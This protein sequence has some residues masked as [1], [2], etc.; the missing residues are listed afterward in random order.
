MA[1]EKEIGRMPCQ[2]NRIYKTSVLFRF[3]ICWVIIIICAALSAD[4]M[5]LPDVGAIDWNHQAAPP[6][7]R[8]TI[9]VKAFNGK[10]VVKDYV[11]LCGTDPLGRDILTRLIFGARVSLMV[12]FGAPAGALIIGGVIGL[13]AG[14]YRGSFETVTSAGMD[15]ILAFPGLVL[16]LFLVFY[17]GPGIEKMIPA[18]SILITPAFF[19]VT[20]ANTLSMARR[21]FI[22]S[23]KAVGAGDMRII[24][25][26]LLPNVAVPVIAY[27]FLIVSIMIVAEGAMSFMGLGVIPPT[28]SW[29]GMIAE[30]KELLEQAPHITLIPAVV[31]FLTV[32]SFNLIGDTLR[33]LYDGM[34]E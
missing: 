33:N 4:F 23:A 8:G 19:R 31:M 1:P 14:Y 30:G 12:G 9:V 34:M 18:L 27:A 2:N 3:S 24:F 25:S 29:G 6:G 32:F 22:L 13:L 7:C 28:P 5:E 11:Y 20:R 26:H 21:D 15:I 16:L 17:F 10:T